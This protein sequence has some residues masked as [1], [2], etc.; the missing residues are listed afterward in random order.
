VV[1]GAGGAAV[2]GA[3]F[4]VANGANFWA[5]FLLVFCQDVGEDWRKYTPTARG[6]V[7]VEVEVEVEVDWNGTRKC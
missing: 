4:L 7:V 3:A 2:V 1:A 6:E 5:T